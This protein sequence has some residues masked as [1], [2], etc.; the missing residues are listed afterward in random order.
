MF[1]SPFVEIAAILL[2]AV[3][4]ACVGSG[5]RQPLIIAFVACGILIGP[6]GLGWLKSTETVKLLADMG[7]SLL[8][9]VVGL[10][11]D[12]HT[13][14]TMGRVALATG[15]GQVG[16]TS[17]F[18][19]LIGLGLGL[20]VVEALYVAVA[21]TFS[22][23]VIIVKLLTDKRELDALHGR[24]AVGF[25]I[26]QDIVVV[27]AMIALSA[28][29][30]AAE[31]GGSLWLRLALVAGKGMAFLGG[32]AL[33]AGLI[34]PRIL[35]WVARSSELLVLFA[36]G[37]AIGLAAGAELLGFSAEVGA[38][39]AGVSLASSDFRD[40]IATRLTVVRDF[41]LLFF[42]LWLGATLDLSLISG[43]IGAAAV[44]S[45]F[46]LIGNPVVVMG[47]MG[48]M[49]YRKRTGFLAGLTVAQ[50][51]EFSLILAALGFGLGHID[52]D[53]VGLV[54]LVGL[55]TITVSTY[56]ILYSGW[57]YE[58]IS[59][60]LGV[61]ERKVPF[62][63]VGGDSAVP[64]RVDAVLVGLGRYGSGIA[65]HLQERGRSVL[66]VDFDPRVIRT[67]Q[68]S[69]IPV[70]YGDALD[71]ELLQHLPLHGARWLVNTTPGRDSNLVLLRLA[72][73]QGFPGRVVLTAH[74]EE[75]ER[76]FK[77]AGADL[78]LR[79]FADAAEQAADVLTGAME[80]IPVSGEWPV[81][82]V[83]VRLRAESPAVGKRISEAPL[84]EK[85]G[86][87]I[88]AVTRAGDT[89][90]D[91]DPN[92]QLFPGDR[93][94]LVGE[95][96]DLERAIAYLGQKKFVARR[97]IAPTSRISLKEVTVEPDSP[98]VGK[99]LRDIAFRQ[100]FGMT[101]VRIR[102]KDREILSPQA[103]EVLEAG[104]ILYVV[105]TDESLAALASP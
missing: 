100:R 21:L 26:V 101:V 48:F 77:T 37:W 39:L 43:Q 65:Q 56:L 82:L 35:G 72:R 10:K 62:R 42:F 61:F 17:L 24:I 66:G 32:L 91:P 18:G 19:F 25:L 12:V 14:R 55:V 27:I 29:G 80:N 54:T 74:N 7:I 67:M 20:G 94:V 23:T 45:A 70:V 2:S 85:T 57:L 97:D 63:E 103:D 81:S 30:G 59:R 93:L 15:L 11:L 13:I 84:R 64:V 44:F 75:E 83:E 73:N 33:V 95:S 46:V 47:I 16:F 28:F 90:F 96:G 86:V 76:E 105:G 41:L 92:L 8:L 49:G 1:H 3:I 71:P 58:R 104:D 36:I 34:L 51:S 52:K 50:I 68:K 88:L 78:V 4:L 102:R 99:S 31:A 60:F 5:L 22:S 40:A 89:I 9:F 38:F 87:T 6:S 69:G 98:W 53:T 79:P